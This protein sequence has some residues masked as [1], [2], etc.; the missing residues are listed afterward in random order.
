MKKGKSKK[1][2]SVLSHPI[3]EYLLILLGAFILAASFNMLLLPNQIASGGVTGLSI[4]IQHL[5]GLEPAYLQWGVNIPLFI[6]GTVL[7]GRKFGLRTA[8]GSVVLPLFIFLTRGFPSL[9]SDA[10]L[11]AIL[12]GFAAGIGVGITFRGKGSTGGLSIVSNIL[13]HKT[14]LS[15]GNC[16]LLLDALVILSA[17]FVFGPE[18]ALYALIAV[19]LTSKAIDIVQVGFHVSKVALVISDEHEAIKEAVLNELERGTTS[20]SA[21]G[22]FTGQEKNALLVVVSQ[23]EV[24]QFRGILKRQDPNAFVILWDSY[25]VLGQGFHR[26]PK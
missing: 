9:T 16:S 26:F 12:G 1:I 4:L 14:G 7:L 21:H 19:Y 5:F 24:N 25:E 22:G 6:L 10:L 15:L 8:V 11:A 23:S 17:G 20:L 18:K 13:H 2:L 3:F